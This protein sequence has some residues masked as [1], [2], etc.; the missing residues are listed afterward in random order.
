M[1]IDE[2][3]DDRMASGLVIASRLRK[4]RRFRFSVLD[5]RFDN[6]VGVR[7]AIERSRRRQPAQR[8]RRGRRQSACPCRRTSRGSSRS[9]VRARSSIGCAD[10]DE[11]HGQSRL[12]EHL[13]DA[14]AHRSRAD[15]ADCFDVHRI[16]SRSSSRRHEGHEG[17]EKMNSSRILRELRVL[18]SMSRCSDRAR[19]PA[20]RR[21]RRRGTAWR[22]RASSCAASA[23]TAAS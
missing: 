5:D 6:V 14:V 18:S 21:C 4:Q 16:A 17:H 3:F 22:C 11:P 7:Q 19:P 2:V 23:R 12:R 13:G 15:D 8:L 9:R 20:R 10:V 1:E